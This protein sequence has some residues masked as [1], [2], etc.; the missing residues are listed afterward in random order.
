MS[1]DAHLE[2]VHADC[3]GEYRYIGTG[4]DG[5]RFECVE[6]GRELAQKLPT[7]LSTWA[8]ALAGGAE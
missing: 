4:D 1:P 6:C 7:V 3:S 5:D 8:K 2:C